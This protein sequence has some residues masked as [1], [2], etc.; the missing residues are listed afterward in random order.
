MISRFGRKKLDSLASPHEV[1]IMVLMINTM[2]I[3]M[4]HSYQF[5]HVSSLFCDK[6]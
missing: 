2:R 1:N 3:I 5:P 4:G 6:I